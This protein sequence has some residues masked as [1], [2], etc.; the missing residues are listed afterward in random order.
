MSTLY[1]INVLHFNVR[2]QKKLV[3]GALERHFHKKLGAVERFL[4]WFFAAPYVVRLF[5]R[6]FVICGALQ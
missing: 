1:G 6:F 5:K 4:M 2:K 3:C